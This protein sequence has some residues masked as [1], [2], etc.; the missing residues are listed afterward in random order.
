MGF[1]GFCRQHKLADAEEVV[2][3]ANTCTTR[4]DTRNPS[5]QIMRT[6]SQA[7]PNNLRETHCVGRRVRTTLG[8]EH[9]VM[10][11]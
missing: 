10:T 5:S 4:D 3:S 8:C 1:G 7:R 6:Q 9:D 2:L 11:T